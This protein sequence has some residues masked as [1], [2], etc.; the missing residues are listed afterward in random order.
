M[1]DS[2][3][4]VYL[5]SLEASRRLM[6]DDNTVSTANES[7]TPNSRYDSSSDFEEDT[8]SDE[9]EDGS[10][11][12]LDRRNAH[13]CWY[14]S[15]NEIKRTLQY[16]T[17][18]SPHSLKGTFTV[19]QAQ[20]AIYLLAE[21]LATLIELLETN[22]KELATEKQRLEQL[23]GDVALKKTQL[24]IEITNIK[25]K[26]IDYPRTVCAA[27]KCTDTVTDDSGNVTNIHYRSHCHPRCRLWNVT[28][29]ITNLE[30]LKNC[31]AMGNNY[32]CSKCG[33]DWSIHM[34]ITFETELFKA[35][36]IDLNVKQDIAKTERNIDERAEAVKKLEQLRKEAKEKQLFFT[37]SSAKFV[38]YLDRNS[39]VKYNDFILAYYDQF[40]KNLENRSLIPEEKDRLDRYKERRRVHVEEKRLFNERAADPNFN[41]TADEIM[42]LRSKIYDTEIN[43]KPIREIFVTLTQDE[44]EAYD[45]VEKSV[46]VS[47]SRKV[48]SS[49]NKLQKHFIG[50]K[51][52]KKRKNKRK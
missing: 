21:P 41:V 47:L 48:K 3:A 31:T 9:G 19:Y 29:R 46:W 6:P 17:S 38:W 4:F 16:L 24:E 10:Q 51:G 35:K 8:S 39:V 23:K 26:K 25:S 49:Y 33:C 14:N 7:V 45:Y 22:I 30:R 50:N 42:D 36:T 43:G 1:I 52:D 13:N 5:A 27:P 11:L 12:D 32:C 34:H 37:K 18:L 15:V 40:I 2:E 44:D 20:K 28:T